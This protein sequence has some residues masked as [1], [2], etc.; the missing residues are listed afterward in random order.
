MKHYKDS[1]ANMLRRIKSLLGKGETEQP[2]SGKVESDN[3]LTKKL[4]DLMSEL[5][6]QKLQVKRTTG[7]R[8]I[9]ERC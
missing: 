4:H 8:G 7:L 2:T 1:A 6:A 3:E 9:L 5:E